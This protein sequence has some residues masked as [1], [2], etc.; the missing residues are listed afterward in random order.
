[1][2]HSRYFD[3]QAAKNLR[4]SASK[5]GSESFRHLL[6]HV[7][8]TDEQTRHQES[9]AASADGAIVVPTFSRLM[10]GRFG[11][12][13]KFFAQEQRTK[14]KRP[15][16]ENRKARVEN[17]MGAEKAAGVRGWVACDKLTQSW[18]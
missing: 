4:R 16:Q 9:F 2:A 17:S 10:T 6:P 7:F 12:T 14:S 3:G 13:N 11:D 5:L 18:S 8:H 1:M 15:H